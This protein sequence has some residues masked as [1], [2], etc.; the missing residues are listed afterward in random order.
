MRYKSN[1]A[2]LKSLDNK[3]TDFFR[4]ITQNFQSE[5]SFE[6]SIKFKVPFEFV[7][8]SVIDT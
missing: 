8:R 5:L 2:N 6:S 1:T 3:F 7:M 4:M